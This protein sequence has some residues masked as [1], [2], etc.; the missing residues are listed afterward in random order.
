MT[1]T[2]KR[3]FDFEAF[4]LFDMEGSRPGVGNLEAVVVVVVLVD[5]VIREIG[6]PD[7]KAEET[8]SI[9]RII[10]YGKAHSGRMMTKTDMQNAIK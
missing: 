1:T 9:N 5:I 3:S 8:I 7:I 6:N 4:L 10:F 2:T